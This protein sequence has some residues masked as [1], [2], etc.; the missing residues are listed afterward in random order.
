MTSSNQ[1]MNHLDARSQYRTNLRQTG[2][3]AKEIGRGEPKGE[4]FLAT[5]NEHITL[6]LEVLRAAVRAIECAQ[7]RG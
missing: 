3:I 2:E 5:L 4:E 6:E 1:F 7:G